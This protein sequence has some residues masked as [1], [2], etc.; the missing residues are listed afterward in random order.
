MNGGNEQ[1]VAIRL[2]FKAGL[3]ATETLVLVLKAYGNEDLNRSNVFSC[4]SRFRDARDLI[5]NDEIGGRHKSSRPEVNIAAVAHLAKNDH[6]IP[7]IM[8]AES[9]NILNA[10]LLRI[11]KEDLR[12]RELCAH[13]FHN[14]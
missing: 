4:Y 11:L 14:S 8:V 1:K 12:N 10:V 9:L 2:C 3:S 5:E 13:L 7:S 6:R